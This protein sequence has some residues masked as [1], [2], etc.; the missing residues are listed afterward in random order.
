M[1]R[2]I[3]TTV[4]VIAGLIL[5][6]DL[7][8]VNPSLG[9]AA[10][11]LQQLLIF[12]AA[13]AAVGGAASL[14]SHHLRVLVAGGGDRLGASV[15]LA[16]MGAILL[17]G[18]RPGSNGTSDPIVL[19][20]V[21]ALLIPIA[22]SL[23]ALLFVFL[24]GAARRGLAVGGRETILLLATASVV[25]ALLLPIGGS[26][27]DW[28]AASAGWVESVPLAGVFRGLL[29]GVAIIAAVTASRIL[30]GIDRDDQ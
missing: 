9:S 10:G 16:G 25:V 6:V 28:L 21:A 17:A 22:S 14:A 29:I 8:V 4:T 27:G 12:L 1:R 23:F 20:L 18:L 5:I 7:L 19:W 26:A 3:T 24:L 11:A 15:L 2:S 13:A 30:L